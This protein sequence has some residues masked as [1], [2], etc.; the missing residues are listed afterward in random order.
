MVSPAASW[1]STALTVTRVSLMQGRPLIRFGSMEIRSYATPQAYADRTPAAEA[2]HLP[3]LSP[4]ARRST[5][6]TSTGSRAHN[7]ESARKLL[8][9]SCARHGRRSYGSA[10]LGQNNGTFAR[11]WLSHRR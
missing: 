11:L 4:A 2:P 10:A 1:P 5:A 9:D 8:A 6:R 7:A 3:R